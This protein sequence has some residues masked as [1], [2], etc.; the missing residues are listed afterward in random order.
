MSKTIDTL[1]PDI[2]QAIRGFGDWDTS[3][4]KTFADELVVIA[5]EK[6]QEPEEHRSYIGMSSLG[7]TCKRDLWLKVNRPSNR[8]PPKGS[9]LLKF[10][11]GHT[12][13]VLVLNLARAAGHSVVG[14]QQEMEINGFL[15][16]RDA[17][18]DGMTID[19]KSAAPVSFDKYK[20][21]GI[22]ETDTFGYVSQIGSYVAAGKNDPLVTEKNKGAILFIN[23]VT[24]ELHLEVLD[25]TED[26]ANKEQEIAELMQMVK[27][28]EPP[29]RL[30]TVPQYKDSPEGNQKLCITCGYC[31]RKHDCFPNMRMFAYSSK[32]EYLTYVD[33]EP[34]V[35][36]VYRRPLM[37][38]EIEAEQAQD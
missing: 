21:K 15:G 4:S 20:R 14:E 5:E 22:R 26:I 32:V 35:Q 6:Y 8:V 17:V 19:I 37:L 25:L 33:K 34:R 38:N 30:A 23:K 18:V 27:L 12:I 2:Y 31:N 24:G 11:F 28:K 7:R 13:E 10:F 16:H 3:V 9:D 1:V 36:E 29:E